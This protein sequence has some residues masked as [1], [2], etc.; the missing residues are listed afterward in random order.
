LNERITSHRELLVY[1]KAFRLAMSVFELSKCFPR[2]ETY[3]LTDQIRRASRAVCSMIAEAWRRRRYEAAFINKL[4]EAEGE[5]AEAQTW[6]EFSVQCGYV[7]KE[8]A[9][10][11]YQEYEEVLKMLVDMINH[12]EDWILPAS[13]KRAKN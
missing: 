9:R 11:L 3:S 10:Q 12:S 8:T 1:K 7:A 13:N 6:I 4:N 5:A 2:E